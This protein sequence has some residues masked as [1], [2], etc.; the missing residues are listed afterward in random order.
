[1]NHFAETSRSPGAYRAAGLHASPTLAPSVERPPASSLPLK[2]FFLLCAGLVASHLLVVSFAPPVADALIYGL[3]AI[4]IFTYAGVVFVQVRSASGML[5]LRWLL[6]ALSLLFYGAN[7]VRAMVGQLTD[8]HAPGF[9]SLLIAIA[10]TLV[11]LAI[12][13]PSGERVARLH[14]L[15]ATVAIVFCALRFL[16]LV[17]L[18]SPAVP[19]SL[20]LGHYTFDPLIRVALALIALSVSPW[21]KKKF[22]RNVAFYLAADL[23]ASFCVNQVGYLWLQQHTASP[24]T[25]TGTLIPLAGGV[26]LLGT[27][28]NTKSQ[29]LI[30]VTEAQKPIL[31]SLLPFAMTLLIVILSATL[32]QAH[33]Y[34]AKLGMAFAAAAFFVRVALLARHQDLT[35]RSLRNALRNQNWQQGPDP[36]DKVEPEA[37]FGP[38][39]WLARAH[40]SRD[41]PLSLLLLKVEEVADG[42]VLVEADFETQN[43]IHIARHL[44]QWR[45][46]HSSIYYFGDSAFAMLL[47]SASH[48]STKQLAEQIRTSIE[49]LGMMGENGFIQLAIGTATAVAPAEADRLI[50]AASDDLPQ[51]RLGR[52]SRTSWFRL[53]NR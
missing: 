35:E 16:H 40:V 33:P 34:I 18:S 50:V 20:V 32:V 8:I 43:L 19:I 26:F 15:D 17:M 46:T 10:A 44:S 5:A 31:R 7:D 13:L 2:L 21:A 53:A 6:F 24:W 11:L 3:W 45:P 51:S 48:R 49:A 1:M 36:L 52:R 39:V 25:L 47:P 38:S 12:T 23:F 30:Q 28:T 29:S 9:D 27:L 22:Y 37:S 41:T 42:L 4:A 14:L